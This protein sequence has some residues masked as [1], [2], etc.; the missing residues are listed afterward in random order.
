[1]S[2]A[3]ERVVGVLVAGTLLSGVGTALTAEAPRPVASWAYDAC[4]DACPVADGAV[5]R[6]ALVTVQPVATR[7]PA[8]APRARTTRPTSPRAKSQPPSLP[9]SGR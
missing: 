6:P 2:R 5:V 7:P 8:P 4:N 3:I 1:M 9:R